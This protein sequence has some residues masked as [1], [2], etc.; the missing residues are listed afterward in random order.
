[1]Q[2]DSTIP[3]AYDILAWVYRNGGSG[4]L[5]TLDPAN[6][7]LKVSA[8]AG[9]TTVQG[10]DYVVCKAHGTFDVCTQDFFAKTYEA[11]PT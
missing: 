3:K 2:Y 7:V 11:A 9:D 6:P 8:S 1:M 5:D 4:S 10:N